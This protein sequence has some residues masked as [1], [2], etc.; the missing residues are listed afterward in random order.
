MLVLTVAAFCLSWWLG[1]YLVGR[2]PARRGLWLAAGA[3][4]AYAIGIA[5]S[6]ETLLCVPALCWAGVAAQLLPHDAPERTL[7]V[8]GWPV[9]ALVFLVPTVLLPGVGKLV[10]LAPLA[11]GLVLLLRYRD[12]VR[13]QQLPLALSNAATLY[14]LALVAVL[15]PLEVGAP[16]LVTASLGLDLL[17]F[18]FLVAVADAVEAGERLFPDLRRSLIAA[19]V[20][21]LLCAGPVA[22]TLLA[23]PAEPVVRVLQFVLVAVV[24]TAVGAAAPVRALLDRVAFLSDDR[25]RRD[26]AALLLAAD[27]LVRRRERHRMIAMDETEFR[28]LT[29][30]ALTDFGDAGRLL[31]NPLV[32][33]PAVDRRLQA[34]G[35]G[36]GEQPL[37]RV[38]ELRALLSEQVDRLRP[39][40]APGTSEEWRF[41][42]ALHY[43]CVLGLRPYDRAPQTD[44][45]DRNARRVLDWIRRYVRREALELWIAQGGEQVATRLWRDLLS[46]DPRWLTR[47]DP[48]ASPTRSTNGR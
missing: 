11:G 13:P 41:Y 39:E 45:L 46:T 40:G 6:S 8:R 17:L 5:A 23:G 25:L 7:V 33:L 2:D 27:A 24:M 44:G 3:L 14:V 48:L 32:E 31:R 34:R 18:G 37:L 26:R 9:A 22:V 29:R 30:R 10:A 42:N 21:G 20:A 43:C 28:R 4:W 35:A 47:S 19:V 12:R 38:A 15:A 16:G 36:A 1:A